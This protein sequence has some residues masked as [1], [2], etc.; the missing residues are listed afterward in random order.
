MRHVIAD[1]RRLRQRSDL[2][3]VRPNHLAVRAPWDVPPP[4]AKDSGSQ[5]HLLT[6]WYDGRVEIIPFRC[7]PVFLA[8]KGTSHVGRDTGE[9]PPR[10]N[11]GFRSPP[12]PGFAQGVAPV[13]PQCH[14][15][16]SGWHTLRAG[17]WHRRRRVVASVVP[18]QIAPPTSPSVPGGG[19]KGRG[20]GEP[21]EEWGWGPSGPATDHR[22]EDR[23]AL[24]FL[25]EH[26][27]SFHACASHLPTAR[28]SKAA[29]GSAAD[30]HTARAAARSALLQ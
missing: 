22:G 23:T 13:A 8:G 19:E 3:S 7:L 10:E 25:F 12:A 14:L 6:P 17:A 24:N 11:N 30:S 28:A 26:C 2:H 20:G 5:I 21:A 4:W 29:R 1:T 15:T 16:P 9:L 27:H 18:V